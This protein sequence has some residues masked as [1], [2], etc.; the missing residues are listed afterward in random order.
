MV[1]D[2]IHVF[3][4]ANVLRVDVLLVVEG[5]DGADDGNVAVLPAEFSCVREA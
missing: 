3:N 5:L 4:H 2:L 1:R